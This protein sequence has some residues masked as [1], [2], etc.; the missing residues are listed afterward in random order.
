MPGP[1][2]SNSYRRFSGLRY[3]LPENDCF[4]PQLSGAYFTTQP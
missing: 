1:D 3:A 2:P 4:E